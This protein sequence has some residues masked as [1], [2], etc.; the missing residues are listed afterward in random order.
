[1]LMKFT[2]YADGKFMAT[3]ATIELDI[4]VNLDGFGFSYEVQTAND[5]NTFET[6]DKAVRFA[7]HKYGV[8]NVFSDEDQMYNE[9]FA[10]DSDGRGEGQIG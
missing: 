5:S 8:R 9:M 2:K 10:M 7:E 4:I 3:N 6:W 1:M